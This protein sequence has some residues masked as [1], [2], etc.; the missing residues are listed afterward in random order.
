[1]NLCR[2]ILLLTIADCFT[3]IHLCLTSASRGVQFWLPTL[4]A[5]FG[6]TSSPAQS[7]LLNIPVAAVSLV[8]NLATGW[9]LDTDTRVPRP[10]IMIGALISLIGVYVGLMF[11]ESSA[12][13]YALILLAFVPNSVSLVLIRH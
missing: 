9:F 6:L 3:V 1:M 4:I 2:E 10:A 8:V 5:N 12:G 11:C 7:Q 13:L